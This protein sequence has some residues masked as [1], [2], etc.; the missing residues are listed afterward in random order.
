MTFTDYSGQKIGR[1]MRDMTI[2][3]FFRPATIVGAL[4]NTISNGQTADAVPLMADL[5]HLVNQ[6]NA[7]AAELSLTPQ[8]ATANS[9]TAVQ[10]GVAAT[11]AANFPIASQV[12]DSALTTLSSVAGANTIT[13]RVAGLAPAAYA[14]G[15]IFSFV[16]AVGNSGSATINING[17]GAA[18]LFKDA[19]TTLSSDDLVAG[20]AHMIRYVTAVADLMATGFHLVN[21]NLT[22]REAFIIACSDRI[23]PITAGTN[24]ASFRMP[25]PFMTDQVYAELGSGQAGGTIF[26]IDVNASGVSMLSTPITI[27]NGEFDSATAATPP[28]ISNPYL[29]SRTLVSVDVD[30]IG[31][32]GSAGLIV[33]LIGRRR[34]A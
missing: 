31:S 22:P 1:I 23:T 16:P 12:Q 15:Q 13:A 19:G 27:D 17:L 14:R 28:V 29:G 33:Q 32:S 11:A 24:K 5:N 26:T 2:R 34:T 9:F 18:T 7:N 6:V 4:P 3:S 30:Q 20:K 8:L 21:A 25:Y 10:S